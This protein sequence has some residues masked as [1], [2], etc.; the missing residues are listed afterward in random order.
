MNTRVEGEIIYQDYDLNKL[1]EK[2]YNKIRG[3][4]IGMIFQDPLGTLNPVM[5]VYK[6]IAE[7]LLYHTDMNEEQRK[8]RVLELLNT[9]LIQEF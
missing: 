9:Y 4:D 2:L 1:N 8:A 7:S 3:N 5:T 6:Q